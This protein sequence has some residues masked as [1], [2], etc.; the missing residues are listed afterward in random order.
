MIKSKKVKVTLECL[1][2][3]V[4]GIYNIMDG[5][6]VQFVFRLKKEQ[7]PTINCFK[8]SNCVE[9]KNQLARGEIHR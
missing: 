4:S 8:A 3:I 7:I 6:Q 5:I 9:L 2:Y 1:I